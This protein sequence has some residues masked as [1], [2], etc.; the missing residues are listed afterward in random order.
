[1]EIKLYN[2]KV[3]TVEA[4]RVTD[5]NMSEVAKWAKGVI[6]VERTDNGSKKFIRINV[7]RPIN[8]KQSKA[9]I[10]DWVLRTK[11][12]FKVYINK[13]FV[14]SFSEQLVYT[15]ADAKSQLEEP[16]DLAGTKDPEDVKEAIA[17]A[18]HVLSEGASKGKYVTEVGK[19]YKEIQEEKAEKPFFEQKKEVEEIVA[20]ANTKTENV[21]DK[22]EPSLC[23]AC[24]L[25]K[26]GL[27]IIRL[28]EGGES[29]R[30][31]ADCRLMVEE[32][33]PTLP[34]DDTSSRNAR[35]ALGFGTPVEHRQI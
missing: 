11:N 20:E 21:F 6:E 14:N 5:E 27:K 12:G 9:F 16:V 26:P 8:D 3:F 15:E 13:A 18:D 29:A 7:H 30:L 28:E 35:E 10:G 33:T 22:E 25:E 34:A 1:M 31:C 32:S 2:R 17:R 4:V 19:A 24:L 23:E